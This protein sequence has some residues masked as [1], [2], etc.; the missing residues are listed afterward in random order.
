MV[1]VIRGVLCWI[2]AADRFFW[3]WHIDIAD[4][5]GPQIDSVSAIYRQ[6]RADISPISKRNILIHTPQHM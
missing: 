4:F 1:H 3:G 6:Y 2:R 5:A